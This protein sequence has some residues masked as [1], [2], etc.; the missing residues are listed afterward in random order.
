MKLNNDI[1]KAI[2]NTFQLTDDLS[3]EIIGDRI[4][5]INGL[6]ALFQILLNNRMPQ[7]IIMQEL[8]Q[9]ILLIKLKNNPSPL[10]LTFMAQIN[11]LVDQPFYV[12]E[13]APSTGFSF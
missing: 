3:N 12:K 9:V 7:K 13:D 8:E 2:F 5:D 11:K 1:Q 10:E 6:P 4:K